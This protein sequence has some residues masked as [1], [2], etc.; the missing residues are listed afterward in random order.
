M[1]EQNWFL[2]YDVP[3]AAADAALWTSNYHAPVD[4]VAD[5]VASYAAMAEPAMPEGIDLE[6]GFSGYRKPAPLGAFAIVA[7]YVEPQL[8]REAMLADVSRAAEAAWM[9][10]KTDEGFDRARGFWDPIAERLMAAEAFGDAYAPLKPKLDKAEAERLVQR[11]RATHAAGRFEDVV[12]GDA[13]SPRLAGYLF[14]LNDDANAGGWIEPGTGPTVRPGSR[15]DA[16]LDAAL[17]PEWRGSRRVVHAN[18][19]ADPANLL[20]TA[21]HELQHLDQQDAGLQSGSNETH[22]D[23]LREARQEYRNRTTSLFPADYAFRKYMADLGEAAART[24]G[25]VQENPSLG[26]W[27]DPVEALR[28]IAVRDGIM[29]PEGRL[30]DALEFNRGKNPMLDRIADMIGASP[31]PDA[32][33]APEMA[34]TGFLRYDGK[35]ERLYAG[36]FGF[37]HY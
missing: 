3:G 24:H 27:S 12:P 6:A 35:W 25:E 13:V 34:Q 21:A 31:H 7:S 36:A 5:L 37:G 15:R 29:P 14:E 16:A 2:D 1:D 9:D 10:T 26:V 17:G 33:H 8:R 18:L 32:W 19:G 28:A 23:Y 20:R 4:P 30:L 22:P 11:A